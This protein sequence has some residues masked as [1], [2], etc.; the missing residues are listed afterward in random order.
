MTNKVRG[1]VEIELDGNKYTACLTLGAL[2]EIE[3]ALELESLDRI[4]ERLKKPRV[5]DV[6]AIL[7]AVLRGGGHD[8]S[9]SEVGRFSGA[10]LT[11][12]GW[13]QNVFNAAGWGDEAGNPTT[14]ATAPVTQAASNGAVGSKSASA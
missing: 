5:R 9:D 2:A 6:V 14:P 7:G 11:A 3:A 12:P 4:G 1:E 10:V 13:I 8:I